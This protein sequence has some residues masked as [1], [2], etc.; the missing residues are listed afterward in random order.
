MQN[1]PDDF[2]LPVG[3]ELANSK[4]VEEKFE[5][6]IEKEGG[7]T[8]FVKKAFESFCSRHGSL[9]VF[10]AENLDSIQEFLVAYCKAIAAGH[11]SQLN[12]LDVLKSTY[13]SQQQQY[14]L[15][16]HAIGQSDGRVKVSGEGCE[17]IPKSKY[18][19]ARDQRSVN[20]AIDIANNLDRHGG[21]WRGI[22]CEDLT[23]FIFLQ[24]RAKI[25]LLQQIKDTEKLWTPPADPKEL[26]KIG[27]N[28]IVSVAPLP[29]CSAGEIH[30]IIAEGLAS[31]AIVGNN[32]SYKLTRPAEEPAV[33]G[34]NLAEVTEHLAREYRSTIH[35]HSRF[36]VA[37][38][39]NEAEVISSMHK[40]TANVPPG[41]NGLIGELG[42]KPFQDALNVAEALL[43]Y[44]RRMPVEREDYRK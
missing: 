19:C 15:I 39:K 20:W 8:E 32:G 3:R 34:G 17:E 35:I 41:T 25:S 26:V 10:D 6:V 38:A 36:A 27:E 11:L 18:I 21:D 33:L 37:L 13:P 4:F 22:V 30:K 14:Q 24:Y 12:V 16:S 44:V 9:V 2:Y 42:P 31:K 1:L 5:E 7:R 29:G 40:F 23:G 28:P 43:P